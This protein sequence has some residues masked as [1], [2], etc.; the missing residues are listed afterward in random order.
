MSSYTVYTMDNCP[1][2]KAAKALLERKDLKYH[3]I[4]VPMSD[5]AQWDALEKR[6]GMKTMPQIFKDD[7]LVG[8]YTELK[9]SLDP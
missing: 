7:Q 8:G 3:E 9:C 4:R 5:D 1:Y 6:T 2:C